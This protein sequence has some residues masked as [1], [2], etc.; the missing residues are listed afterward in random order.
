MFL[1][2][3]TLDIPDWVFSFHIFFTYTL[4]FIFLQYWDEQKA[5]LV[6]A[7]ELCLKVH[8]KYHQMYNG[9]C[10]NFG[11]LYCAKNLYEEA[12][13]YYSTAVD[14]GMKMYGPNHPV[15]EKR[16]RRMNRRVFHEIR[17]RR[18]LCVPGNA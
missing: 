10:E 11:D 14:I 12:Y 18:E 6:K 2:K 4:S 9:I 8:G 5:D 3:K 15:T 1:Y 13:D 17:R 7:E 16:K